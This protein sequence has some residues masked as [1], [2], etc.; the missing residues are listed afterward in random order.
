MPNC[1]VEALKKLGYFLQSENLRTEIIKHGMS[2]IE[3]DVE[4]PD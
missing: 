2:D 1:K 4:Q 3:K